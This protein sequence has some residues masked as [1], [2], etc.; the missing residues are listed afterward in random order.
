MFRKVSA[1]PARREEAGN[2]F[3]GATLLLSMVTEGLLTPFLSA[4]LQGH[5]F[6][7]SSLL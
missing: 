7:L 5:G 6:L 2:S 4:L 1:Q 3:S